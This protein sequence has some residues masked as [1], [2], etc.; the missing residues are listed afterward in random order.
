M[1]FLVNG[2]L[3]EHAEGEDG[4]INHFSFPATSLA[5]AF[6]G[7]RQELNRLHSDMNFTDLLMID[8]LVDNMGS[9][10][11]ELWDKE[12]GSGLYPPPSLHVSLLSP[13]IIL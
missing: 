6:M 1:W 3:P 12:G 9:A 7:R 2:L 10:V 11:K 13:R 5:Q 4:P 8:G